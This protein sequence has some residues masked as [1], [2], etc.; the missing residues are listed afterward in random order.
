[1][2]KVKVTKKMTDWARK[3]EEKH[4][5]SIPKRKNHTG[6]TEPDR[7]YTGKL[8]EAV[9]GKYLTENN[10]SFDY[11]P[12]VTK[13]GTDD[14][15]F[16]VHL[17]EETLG[18]DKVTIDVK[19]CSKDFHNLLIIPDKHLHPKWVYVGVRIV[20]DVGQI[21]GFCGVNDLKKS[22]KSKTNSHDIE[23]NDLRP[24]EK[25]LDKIADKQGVII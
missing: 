1:M 2:Y 25:M 23:L 6:I 15:D 11:Q 22:V 24:M 16:D 21:W 5:K 12:R 19:T 20:K 7:Y 3:E 9:F 13:Y 14:G 8:G 4:L 10:K 18:F 17:K